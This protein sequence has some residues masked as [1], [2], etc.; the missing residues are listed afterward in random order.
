MASSPPRVAGDGGNFPAM[1]IVSRGIVGNGG[2]AEIVRI[3][4][5]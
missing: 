1:G 3:S 4:S 5:E 2:S